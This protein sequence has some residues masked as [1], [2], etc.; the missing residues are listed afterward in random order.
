MTQRYEW[1]SVIVV[2]TLAIFQGLGVYLEVWKLSDILSIIPFFIF[3][4]MFGVFLW[5]L[6]KRIDN[7]IGKRTEKE[8]SSAIVDSEL[9]RAKESNV[10]TFSH[11]TIHYS[12]KTDNPETLIDSAQPIYVT[13]NKT[14][15]AF[16]VPEW[17]KPYIYLRKISLQFHDGE[18]ALLRFV[19]TYSGDASRKP[20]LIELGLRFDE[21]M[22]VL[23]Q[24]SDLLLKLKGHKLEDL[25]VVFLQR[26]RA[27]RTLLLKKSTKEAFEAPVC[28][29]ELTANGIIADWQSFR[30]WPWENCKRWSKRQGYTFHQWRFP[31]SELL[32]S[33]S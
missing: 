5:G 1:V 28:V 16:L 23:A 30:M 32:K 7:L 26:I 8:V 29:N 25:R 13:N 33:S 6:G 20:L 19:N 9:K 10:S 4:A 17:L 11:L 18:R 27:R 21:E 31:E 12:Q 2:I 15:M 3:T 14:R 22:L 24:E